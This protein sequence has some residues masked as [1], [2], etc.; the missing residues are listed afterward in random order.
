M[1]MKSFGL[2]PREAHPPRKRGV[3]KKLAAAQKREIA[4]IADKTGATND[5]S[6]TPEVID[7]TGAEVGRFYRPAKR[8]VTIR[9]DDDVIGWLKSYGRGYQTKAN[10]LLRHAMES[11]RRTMAKGEEL[12]NSATERGIVAE[13]EPEALSTRRVY[14]AR[15]G[16]EPQSDDDPEFIRQV[17]MA[18]NGVLRRCSPA[19][20]ALI[21]IDNWFDWKWLGFP[22]GIYIG[23]Y[24]R[25][26]PGRI[27]SDRRP[28]D[29]ITI[30]PFVPERVVSQRRFAAPEYREIDPG[31]PV[32]LHLRNRLALR[33]KAAAEE[34]ETALAW[35]SGNS[36]ANG[37]G[38]LMVYPPAGAS[39]W[40]WYAELTR[41]EPWRISAKAKNIKPDEFSRLMEEGSASL[42]MGDETG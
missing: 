15:V 36:K 41:G 4:A 37:R 24:A 13:S 3:M 39:Y 40:P 23:K 29:L 32:H 17:E 7:W 28:R 33:R 31:K 30:P 34:P 35:Y 42:A 19:A 9:L 11:S 6:D 20:L 14:S 38:A 26:V 1:K 2:S 12:R 21:K 27:P 18:L 5:F 16:I 10:L 8:P 22:G 25:A